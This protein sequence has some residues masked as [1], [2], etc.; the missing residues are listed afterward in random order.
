M[1]PKR[2]ESNRK[3]RYAAVEAA[4]D[5][6]DASATSLQGRRS[7]A[8]ALFDRLPA[9]GCAIDTDHSPKHSHSLLLKL[10]PI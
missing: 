7:T 8:H 1:A 4:S 6:D 2:S 5:E 10:V 9:N 3:N